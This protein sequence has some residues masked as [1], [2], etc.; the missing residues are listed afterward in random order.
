M[1]NGEPSPSTLLVAIRAKCMDCSGNSRNEV[2]RCLIKTCPLYPYR[3]VDAL[4][5]VME[6]KSTA[7]GQIDMFDLK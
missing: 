2:E 7:C 5:R 6:P 3:S 4:E 1:R